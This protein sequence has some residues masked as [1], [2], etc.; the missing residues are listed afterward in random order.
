MSVAKKEGP[1][2]W[3]A[4]TSGDVTRHPHRQQPLLQD[5]LYRGTE[6]LDI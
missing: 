4:S 5:A 1:G 2:R 3:G 6:S